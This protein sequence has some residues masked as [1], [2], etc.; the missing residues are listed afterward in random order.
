VFLPS[1]EQLVRVPWVESEMQGVI[2]DFSD[3]GL[4]Q[5]AFAIV[6]VVGGLRI[7]VPVEKLKRR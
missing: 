1:Q 6:E 7:V 2:L 4:K 3:S 5:R